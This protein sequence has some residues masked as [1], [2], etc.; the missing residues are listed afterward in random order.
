MRRAGHAALAAALFSTMACARLNAPLVDVWTKPGRHEV[1]GVSV[2]V[3]HG[4]TV[5]RDPGCGVFTLRMRREM[6]A[7]PGFAY[8]LDVLDATHLTPDCA[9][10]AEAR[11]VQ[12]GSAVDEADK[13][14]YPT[15][16]GMSYQ[17]FA[18]DCMPGNGC[19]MLLGRYF[20][21]NEPPLTNNY[22]DIARR[23]NDRAPSTGGSV[24]P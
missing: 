8:E 6:R 12:L 10:A 19:E 1:M 22:R 23:A 14:R 21:Q 9:I 11:L 15:G 18:G 7:P 2:D 20:R 13:Q 3:A 4:R 17:L 5:L 16:S 24:T